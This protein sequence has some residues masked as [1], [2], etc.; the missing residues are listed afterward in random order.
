MTLASSV[1]V[2]IFDFNSLTT[3]AGSGIDVHQSWPLQPTDCPVR[4]MD[5][6]DVGHL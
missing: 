4:L 2:V 1:S 6:A 3:T 5:T